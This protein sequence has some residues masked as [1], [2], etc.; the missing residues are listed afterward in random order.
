MAT[1]FSAEAAAA[2]A[3]ERGEDPLQS[4]IFQ[5]LGAASACWENLR[6]AGV[7]ESDRAVEIGNDVMA[8]LRS[9]E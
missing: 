7:F 9:R 2:E 1:G 4:V 8:Y 3:I 6:G 5:A